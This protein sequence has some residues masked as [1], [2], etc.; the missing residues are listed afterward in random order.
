MYKLY[1]CDNHF[2]NI[3]LNKVSHSNSNLERLVLEKCSQSSNF[4]ILLAW[5]L[6]GEL[7]QE[8]MLPTVRERGAELRKAVEKATID[9]VLPQRLLAQKT[10]CTSPVE[11]TG[12]TKVVKLT[13]DYLL[14]QTFFTDITRAIHDLTDLS[15]R[16]K[17]YPVGTLRTER[18]KKELAEM[19]DHIPTGCYIP[20]CK[21]SDNHE[22]VLR[23]VANECIALSTKERVPMMVFAEVFINEFT[24]ASP[25][26]TEE[27][28]M[29]LDK[30]VM[31]DKKKLERKMSHKRT[32]SF[33]VQG[34]QKASM[35]HSVSMVDFKMPFL[36]PLKPIKV[37]AET[38]EVVAQEHAHDH[39]FVVVDKE[40]EASAE[41][42]MFVVLWYSYF[43][44]STIVRSL[45]RKL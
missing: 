35:A 10:S 37:K 42:S 29:I 39:D 14:R 19:N 34:L 26:L 43:Y 40:H 5:L 45:W 44:R 1:T 32:Q 16:L 3:Y 13:F 18:M 23:I 38:S 22:R 21:S 17:Q 30:P 15:L 12:D 8:G 41:R 27:N 4:G 7:G 24:A 9:R 31:M 11:E 20:I 28:I 2:R 33:D 6:D 36:T 25:V